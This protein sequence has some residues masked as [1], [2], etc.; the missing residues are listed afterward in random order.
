MNSNYGLYG[1]IWVL[2][3]VK[4]FAL[5]SNKED[6]EKNEGGSS[7]GG[8]GGL[9]CSKWGRKGW[10]DYRGCAVAWHAAQMQESEA[11]PQG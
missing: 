9:V 3:P 4:H 10:T 6:R 5:L 8:W 7:G 2:W 11:A 1:A